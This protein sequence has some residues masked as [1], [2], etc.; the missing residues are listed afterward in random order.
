MNTV[1]DHC[2][3]NCSIQGR[4]AMLADFG[5]CVSFRGCPSHQ[6]TQSGGSWA[7]GASPW[8]NAEK[9]LFS[10]LLLSDAVPGPHGMPVLSPFL[11]ATSHLLMCFSKHSPFPL[12][13]YL[14]TYLTCG[15]ENES[16]NPERNLL[17]AEYSGKDED[18]EAPCCWAKVFMTA[19][20]FCL[21][22]LSASIFKMGIFISLV[23]YSFK[24]HCFRDIFSGY[25]VRV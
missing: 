14:V 1:S 12:S 13:Y 17:K 10:P 16:T 4:G 19:W 8:G 21:K 18:F 15:I 25:R 24:P 22:H 2:K 11:I 7:C 3:C 9:L 5:P 20:Y 6:W 23:D